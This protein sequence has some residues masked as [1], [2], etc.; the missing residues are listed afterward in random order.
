M[1]SA[2]DIVKLGS[3]PPPVLCWLCRAIRHMPVLGPNGKQ[4]FPLDNPCWVNPGMKP[5]KLYDIH[6][7]HLTKKFFAHES[8][9]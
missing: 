4:T 1:V 9:N 6:G 8:L 5:A 2:T 3:L 7:V